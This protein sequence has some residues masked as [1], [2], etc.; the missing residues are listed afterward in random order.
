MFNGGLFGLQKGRGGHYRSDYECAQT[1]GFLSHCFTDVS[2]QRGELAFLSSGVVE[3]PAV[4]SAHTV[5]QCQE[6]QLCLLSTLNT[7][8][9]LSNF[10]AWTGNIHST[11]M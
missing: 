7:L 4:L 1:S 2:L 5:L 8:T 11:Y 10:T 3:S 6:A 9:F